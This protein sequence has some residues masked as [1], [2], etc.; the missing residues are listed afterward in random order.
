MNSYERVMTAMQLG[1]PDRVPVVEFAIDPGVRHAICP[2][3]HETYELVDYLDLD[4]VGCGADFR[5][6][7]GD[8][9]SWIDEWG[10]R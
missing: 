10:V 8:D 9:E 4:N 1:Q 7:E 5:R 3:A 2:S 6:V